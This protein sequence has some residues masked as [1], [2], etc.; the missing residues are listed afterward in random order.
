MLHFIQA[1][2]EDAVRRP[3]L[4]ILKFLLQKPENQHLL[5]GPGDTRLTMRFSSD[6]AKISKKI[7]AVRGVV[8][9]YDRTQEPSNHSSED[10]IS[11]Y[12]YTGKLLLGLFIYFTCLHDVIPTVC[13]N[14][15]VSQA[16]KQ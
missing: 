11:I 13:G 4:A 15:Y 5:Q 6:G 1:E 8:F 7:N 10:E 3:L 12:L 14:M 2:S 16:Q 9:L